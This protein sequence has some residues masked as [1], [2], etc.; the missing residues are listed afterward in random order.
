TLRA[1]L[2]YVGPDARLLVDQFKVLLLNQKL[3]LL[4]LTDCQPSKRSFSLQGEGN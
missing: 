3:M 2:Q 1:V 4:A